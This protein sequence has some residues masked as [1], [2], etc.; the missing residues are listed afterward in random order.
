MKFIK[1]SKFSIVLMLLVNLFTMSC[2]KKDEGSVTPTV[3][4]DSVI[5][6]LVVR[7]L[8]KV[9]VSDGS[10]TQY[11][12]DTQGRCIRTDGRDTF[13][14]F[15]YNSNTVVESDNYNNRVQS[16]KIYTL[17]SKGLAISSTYVGSP[18]E[19]TEY[20][21]NSDDFLIRTTYK[22]K[23]GSSYSIAGEHNYTWDSDGD[24][25]LETYRQTNSYSEGNTRKKEI[26]K[27]HYNTTWN[28]EYTGQKWRGKSSVH[29]I[30]SDA[31]KPNNATPITTKY[32]FIFD[33]K[34]YTTRWGSS[35]IY[36]DSYYD[37]TYK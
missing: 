12:Y 37:Y 25:L 2:T 15:V 9:T 24:L 6:P 34:G 32:T 14:T 19:L 16:T 28:N 36:G 23:S 27:K 5:T 13:T 17:N 29:C 7:K 35:N 22:S 30:I 1:F 3:P 20:E 11:T 26:D 21:Y 4:K 8:D 10:F 31:Y 33:S 18:L